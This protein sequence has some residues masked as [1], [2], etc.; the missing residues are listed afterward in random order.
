[1]QCHERG[2]DYQG[3]GVY[4]LYTPFE[5]IGKGVYSLYI[6]ARRLKC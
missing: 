3:K 5:M 4:R 2:D 1:M 6:L